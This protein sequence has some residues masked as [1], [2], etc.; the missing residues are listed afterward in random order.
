MKKLPQSF[1]MDADVFKVAKKL[2]GKFLVTNFNGIITSGMITEVEGY[3]GEIDSA[4]HAFKARRTQR[5][6]IMY[7]TGGTAY[8]YICYGIHH[9]FNVITNEKD[10]PHAILI[11]SIEP[12]ENIDVMMKRRGKKKLDYALTAGP[13]ALS[14][15][16]GIHI[17]HNGELLYS[18]LIWIEDRGV[19]IHSRK[20]V[21]TIR[22]GVEGAGRDARLP[23]RYIIEGNKW[24]TRTPK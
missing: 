7:A 8:V 15:A 17:K 6:E 23:Y 18:N 12:V 5:N 9:L 4:S 20:I 13:G 2:L 24:I 16:L 1:Y 19:K 21:S 22:V 10:I 3:N 14:K 11:R